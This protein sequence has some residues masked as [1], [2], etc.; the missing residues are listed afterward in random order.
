VHLN[1]KFL[2]LAAFA[3]I[4][5]SSTAAL[6]DA[7]TLDSGDIGQSY[8]F[9]Y[10]GF[11][12]GTSITGLTASTTFTLTGVASNSY[13]FGYSVTNT[14]SAPLTSRVSSFAFNADPNISSASSTGAFSFTTL[15]S[16]YPNGIGTVDACFKSVSTGSCAGGGAASS[17]PGHCRP[18]VP[19]SRVQAPECRR[20]TT[21]SV[22]PNRWPT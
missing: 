1:R 18:G 10:N 22:F 12:G 7:I 8:S 19:A 13:T 21:L 16:N 20:S 6:A 4:A 14:T 9:S 2:P 15:N 17:L 11:S 3:A 5:F